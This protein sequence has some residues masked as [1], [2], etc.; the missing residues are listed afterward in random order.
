MA[1]PQCPLPLVENALAPYIHS[2]EKTTRIR[3]ILTQS[4]RKHVRDDSEPTHLSLSSPSLSL[5]AIDTALPSDGLYKQYLQALT[6]HRQA[7]ARYEDIKTELNHALEHNLT[8]NGSTSGQSSGESVR[9]YSKLL[10]GRRQQK[11]LEIIQDALTKLL[12]SE[13][14]PAQVDVKLAV[15]EELGEPPQAPIASFEIE[16]DPDCG[17]EDLVFQLKKELLIA[18]SKFSEAK[19][20]RSEAERS[21][22]SNGE[23]DAEQCVAIL[24]DARDELISWVETEL[25][26]IPEDDVEASQVE[27]SFLDDGGDANGTLHPLSHDELS[28]QVQGLYANYLSARDGYISSVESALERTQKLEASAATQAGAPIQTSRYQ[29][30]PIGAETKAP[31]QASQLLPYLTNITSI[32]KDETSLQQHTSHLRRQLT[33]ASEET[34]NVIQRLAGESLLVPQNSTSMS[35]WSKA[36]EE[37]GQQTQTAV[38]EHVNEG[39]ASINHAKSVLEGL[40]ARKQALEGLKRDL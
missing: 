31:L 33:I 11:K 29:M 38:L 14:N 7:Q 16:A 34:E 32:T 6:A 28:Q 8:P 39:E 1:R 22:Q 20:L 4:L 36:S 9:E 30:H 25:G 23:I 12:D 3:Q 17:I 13:P 27:M 2:R 37:A 5:Q 40:R 10:R 15:R 35:A 19:N 24:R 21:T 26:K 18:K